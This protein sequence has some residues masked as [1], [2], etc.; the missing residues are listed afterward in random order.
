MLRSEKRFLLVVPS[1]A[2]DLTGAKTNNRDMKLQ[3]VSLD[4]RSNREKI[5]SEWT[6]L[7]NRVGS[8]NLGH[9]ADWFWSNIDWISPK[10]NRLRFVMVKQNGQLVGLFPLDNRLLRLGPLRVPSLGFIDS[11]YAPTDTAILLDKGQEEPVCEAFVSHLF[12]QIG[13]WRCFTME[14]SSGDG[15]AASC[16]ARAL[17]RRGI[18]IERAEESVPLMNLSAGWKEYIESQSVNFRRGI[19]RAQ[20]RLESM[21]R[22]EYVSGVGDSALDGIERI[23]KASWRML[24]PKDVEKNASVLRYCRNLHKTFPD[25]SKHI[26]RFLHLDG[27]AVAGL[28]G[29]VYEN[30]FYAVKANFDARYGKGSPG[31]VLLVRVFEECAEKGIS[32]IELFG[33]NE[34]LRRLSNHSRP[35]ARLLVC[36]RRGFGTLMGTLIKFAVR[37][38]RSTKKAGEV[39]RGE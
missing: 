23:D 24:K 14:G 20:N 2:G 35:L 22:V 37:I 19:R 8:G 39:T 1:S 32:K 30:T 18:V 3:T 5:H 25:E 6:G 13:G 34:Y 7:L 15:R 21:G 29:L 9:S 17:S 31:L 11:P 28:Y 36:N 27:N 4:A 26:I 38:K 12:E 16:L 33:K 10:A